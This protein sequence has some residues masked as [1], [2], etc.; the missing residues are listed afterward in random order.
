MAKSERNP[1]I[2]S[3]NTEPTAASCRDRSTFAQYQ[4]LR[5]SPP[6]EPGMT[7]LKNAPMRQNRSKDPYR[8]RIPWTKTRA[9]HRKALKTKSR[10]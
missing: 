4:A 1:T 7:L 2:R 8:T 10:P 9:C 5:M 6:I 3:A